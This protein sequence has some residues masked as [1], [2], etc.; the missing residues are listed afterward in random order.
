MS[1]IAK[2]KTYFCKLN[3]KAMK[4]RLLF[5]VI[6]TSLLGNAQQ[7]EFHY[8]NAGNQ[9]KR[10]FLFDS[11]RTSKDPVKDIA[12]LEESDLL[13]FYPQDA[14]S[15]YPNP[16]NEELYIKWEITNDTSVTSIEVFSLN[17]QFLEQYKITNKNNSQVVV[18]SAYPQ[19]IYNVILYYSNGSKK[20]IKIIKK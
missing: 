18:F 4:T 20:A 3:T 6:L 2:I 11:G 10:E 7:I 9:I 5:I 8:D 13:K 15:Y 1:L 12:D 17:G 19:G 16:V 14:L